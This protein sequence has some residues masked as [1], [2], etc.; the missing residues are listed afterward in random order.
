[1]H[2]FF[3]P[4]EQIVESKDE[5]RITGKDYNH[6]KNVLRIQIGEEV[7]VSNGIDEREYCC[8]LKA[9]LEE[10]VILTICSVSEATTELSANI[11]L[12]QGLPKSDKMEWIVQKATEL[13]VHEIVPVA[14]KRCVVKF[15][16]KKAKSKVQRWQTI[17]ESAAKQSK[18]NKIP[19]VIKLHTYKEAME[20][21]STMDL[22]CIP[23]ELAKGMQETREWIEQIQPGQ[24]V[25]IFIGPEG[26]FSEEEIELARKQNIQ[27]ITLGRRILRTETAG[28][29][30]LAFI[31]YHLEN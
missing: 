12:F 31:M 21:A 23:Y 14:T 20:Y 16:E 13:G 25:G 28:L 19:N 29:T 17:A 7:S 5:I 6:A 2:H 26:G 8:E 27:P 3:V 18:R 10:E 4:S 1:M 30:T 9:F 22:L 11:I 24:R 15:D